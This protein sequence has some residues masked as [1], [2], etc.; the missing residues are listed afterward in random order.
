MLRRRI[1]KQ[2]TGSDRGLFG[3]VKAERNYRKEKEVSRVSEAIIPIYRGA[4]Y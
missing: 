4:K 3:S 2:G 1:F